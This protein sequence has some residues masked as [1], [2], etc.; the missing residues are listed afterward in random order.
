MKKIK[1]FINTFIEVIKDLTLSDLWFLHFFNT[2]TVVYYRLFNIC[3]Q[4]NIF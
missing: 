4:R 2:T 3:Y 1:E